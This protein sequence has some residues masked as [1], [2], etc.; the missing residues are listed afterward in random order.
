VS[1]RY[2][3]TTDPEVAARRQRLQEALA[4][5]TDEVVQQTGWLPRRRGWLL[6][7][8]GLAAGATLAL[9]LKAGKPHRR[10]PSRDPLDPD[11]LADSL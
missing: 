2:R 1:G 10:R 8:A 7:L 4:E 11:D 3:I 9:S 6:V 5:V